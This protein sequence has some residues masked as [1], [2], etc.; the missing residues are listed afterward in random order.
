ME[1]RRVEEREGRT[2]EKR[3]EGGYEGGE[4]KEESGWDFI[5][6]ALFKPLRSH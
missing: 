3:K 5:K 1:E 2:G 4:G 6:A